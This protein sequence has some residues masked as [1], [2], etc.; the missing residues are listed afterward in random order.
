[1]N[2]SR[3]LGSQASPAGW[4]TGRREAQLGAMAGCRG[5]F[6]LE[7]E[8]F[9]AGGDFSKAMAYMPLQEAKPMSQSR[10]QREGNSPPR[11]R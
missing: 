4:R 10:L 8:R 9:F 1:M 5:P 6:V 3:R 2:I 7:A 11:S